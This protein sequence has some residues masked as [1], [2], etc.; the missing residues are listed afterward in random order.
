[1]ISFAAAFLGAITVIIFLYVIGKYKKGCKKPGQKMDEKTPM[2][3]DGTLPRVISR[4]P[5]LKV[6]TPVSTNGLATSTLETILEVD[7]S[8]AENSTTL[9]RNANSKEQKKKTRFADEIIA[10]K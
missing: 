7:Q 1:M 8:I 4:G 5:Y 9:N 3:P 10:Q 6:N 2:L